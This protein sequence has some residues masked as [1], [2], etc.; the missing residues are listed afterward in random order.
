[1]VVT[2]VFMLTVDPSESLYG[3][4]FPQ[5]FEIH[6]RCLDAL[7]ANLNSTFLIDF[8]RG[9]RLPRPVPSRLSCGADIGI[10]LAHGQHLRG[11]RETPYPLCWAHSPRMLVGPRHYRRRP[12]PVR[13]KLRQSKNRQ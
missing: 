11:L 4:F 7:V 13:G 5:G 1:M 6:E 3:L 8:S 2:A 9:L 10:L 12:D